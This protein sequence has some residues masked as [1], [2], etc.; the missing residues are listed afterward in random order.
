MN[1]RIIEINLQLKDSVGLLVFSVKSKDDSLFKDSMD[2]FTDDFCA[3][4]DN[5]ENYINETKSFILK[6]DIDKF[7]K[8]G[9]RVYKI[10]DF[11]EKMVIDIHNNKELK[12]IFEQI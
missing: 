1:K 3:F 10:L 7:N 12:K 6:K 11:I 5:V 9:E 4:R 2:L 8:F